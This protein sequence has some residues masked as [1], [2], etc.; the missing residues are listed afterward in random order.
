MTGSTYECS[1]GV[2]GDDIFIGKAESVTVVRAQVKTDVKL[3]VCRNLPNA[4]GGSC[5]RACG[6]LREL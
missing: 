3:Q 2:N 5:N 6:A 4:D 1:G